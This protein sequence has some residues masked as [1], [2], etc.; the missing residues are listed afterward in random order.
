MPS[1]FSVQQ[2]SAPSSLAG[3][4]LPVCPSASLSCFLFHGVNLGCST[5]A[6]IFL[7]FF[8]V[9]V[10][11][12]QKG[13]HFLPNVVYEKP[14]LQG[15]VPLLFSVSSCKHTYVNILL[16]NQRLSAFLNPMLLTTRSNMADT[17]TRFGVR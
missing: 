11:F 12:L 8:P 14:A 2:P 3:E 5:N 4:S 16:F 9:L 1:S 6:A 7:Y 17:L 13:H 10:N 15:P